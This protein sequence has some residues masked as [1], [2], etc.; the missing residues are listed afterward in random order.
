MTDPATQKALRKGDVDI[1]IYTPLDCLFDFASS[2]WDVTNW[3][4][5]RK[6]VN[7]WDL[8]EKFPTHADAIKSMS[9]APEVKRHRLGHIINE[10]NDDLIPL[11]TFYHKKTSAM[12]N[13]RA[14]LFL[15]SDICLFDG[16]LP[17]QRIP[18]SRITADEQINSPFPYSVSMD[19]LPLQK[20]YNA[21]CSAVCTNQAA[22]G[23]QNIL[24]PRESNISLAQLTEGLN[25]LYYD[26]QITQGSKPEPLN[27][28]ATAPE[29]FKWIE[30]IEAMMTKVSGINDTIQGHPEANIKSGTAMAFVAAQALAFLSPLSRSYTLLMENTWTRLIDILKEFATTPRMVLI[31][32]ISNR[33]EAKEFKN[34]DIA[35]ID[36]VIV[37][38]G[39][40][41]MQTTAG[42]IQIAENLLQGGLL[43][44]EEYLTV[45]QTGQLEPIYAYEKEELLCIK[46]ENEALQNGRPVKALITDNHPLHMRE[47]LTLLSS[48]E[49]RTAENNPIMMAILSHL[50][51]HDNLWKTMP[52]S[53]AAIQNIPPA[54]QPMMPPS[55]APGTGPENPMGSKVPGAPNLPNV[56]NPKQGIAAQA[57]AIKAPNMPNLPP[58]SPA[59]IQAGHEAMKA[60][61]PK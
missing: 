5:L 54:P 30:Y 27:L 8:V 6:Y 7:R 59:P 22:F 1:N 47:H 15:D 41:L 57:G 26:P 20:V 4:I 9:I 23:V 28:L 12:P 16:D 49:A 46:R 36:R 39:N 13:G 43:N 52:A 40:P 18:V 58:G 29:V 24:I 38:E 37:E 48:P 25:A 44:K 14:T 19:L 17:Y 50:Q 61:L 11:Y 33:S 31:S 35:N 51:E 56:L 32:G 55:G 60:A 21:L 42:R 3:I 34:T 2:S 45:V 10:K 53:F